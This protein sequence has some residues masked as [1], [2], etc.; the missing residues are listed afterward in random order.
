[1]KIT[2]KHLYTGAW[3]V[4]AVYLINAI[5]NFGSMGAA[6]GFVQLISVALQCYLAYAIQRDRNDRFT[7][8]AV[9]VFVI[10]SFNI[11]V[12]LL[13]VMVLCRRY[14]KLVDTVQRLWFLPGASMAILGFNNISRMLKYN[15]LTSDGQIVLNIVMSIVNVVNYLILGYWLIR[16]LEITDVKAKKVE[17]DKADRIAFYTKLYQD[18]DITREELDEKLAQIENR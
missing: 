6:W 13:L 15:H 1:M 3:I 18:G 9:V 8:I 11:P 10:T 14:G 4:A 5:F 17:G 16:Q 2:N 12:A 7:L